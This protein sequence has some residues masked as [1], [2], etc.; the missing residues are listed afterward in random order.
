MKKTSLMLLMLVPLLAACSKTQELYKDYAYNSSNFMENYYMEHNGVE[1]LSVASTTKYDFTKDT[2]IYSFTSANS[3]DGIRPEDKSADYP[4]ENYKE[5][6]NEFGRQNNLTKIDK[7]FAY[8]YLSKLYDGRVRCESK[9]QLSRVQLDK[10][11]YS[12]FFPKKLESYK[13][14]AFS[15]RGA[16]DYY[17]QGKLAPIAGENCYID[18]TIKFYKNKLNSKDYDVVEFNLPNVNIP[19][20]AGGSTNLVSM[21]LDNN[22][23]NL[24]DTVA[25]SFSYTLK[26]T[27]PELSDDSRE[28][29]QYHFAVMLYEVMFPKSTWL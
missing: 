29:S 26:S 18:A 19:C 20:D 22:G 28:E 13:Y 10:N 4:W 16:T 5:K 8:G 7:S 2:G 23:I 11:G 6:E 24:V 3:Y 25:M 21:Y 27:A 12:T 1:K 9:Y 15:L 17:D 14:F